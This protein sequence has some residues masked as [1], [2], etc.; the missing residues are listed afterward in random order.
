MALQIPL[1]NNRTL[2]TDTV[3]LV[4]G[5]LNITPDSFYAGSRLGTVSAAVDAALEM[6]R[7]GAAILDIGGESTRP[8]AEAVSPQEEADRVIPVI[9]AIR[10]RSD[11][12]LSVDTRNAIV[13]R[14]ALNQGADIVN[15]V[16]A[17]RHD[18]AMLP[19]VAEYDVPVVI[20]HMRGT[21]ETMQNNPVYD[22]VVGEIFTWLKD[23]AHALVTAGVQPSKIIVDPGIGFGKTLEHNLRILRELPTFCTLGYPVLLGASRK[24]FIGRVLETRN[25]DGSQVPPERRGAGSLAIHC[26][27]AQAGASILRVHDV[28]ETVDAMRILN[29]LWDR[30]YTHA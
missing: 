27:A 20:M 12:A 30:E 18:P 16:S 23:R 10:E 4:M 5:I 11:I 21:P 14:E 8:G 1:R 6:E 15:D 29:A 2:E 22:D 17:L 24:R 7:T 9:T 3:P 13:A 28:A 26:H 25:P 19:L